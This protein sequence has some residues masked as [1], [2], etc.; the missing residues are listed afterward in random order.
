MVTARAARVTISLI[1]STVFSLSFL[2][3]CGGEAEGIS[4][5]EVCGGLTDKAAESLNKITSRSR[6]SETSLANVEGLA[7]KITL[8]GH[9]HELCTISPVNKKEPLIE[10]RVSFEKLKK[11]PPEERAKGLLYFPNIGVRAFSDVLHAELYFQCNKELFYGIL[12]YPVSDPDGWEY[13]KTQMTV[14]QD[15]SYKVARE[16]KCADSAQIP[17]I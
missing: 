1:S 2:T 5:N 10:T 9:V 8:D 13:Q 3:A 14:L 7:R 17:K 4:A 11:L 12:T 6:Y 15:I 16:L